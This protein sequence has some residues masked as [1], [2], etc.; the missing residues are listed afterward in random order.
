MAHHKKKK[1]TTVD[2]VTYGK[3]YDVLVAPSSYD[4]RKI[5]KPSE[6]RQD[7]GATQQIE[8]QNP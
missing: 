7:D 6:L 5:M 4:S 1:P 2:K 3:G 8:E